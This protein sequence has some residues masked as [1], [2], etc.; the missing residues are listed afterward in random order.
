MISAS[1][2]ELLRGRFA[3]I[4]HGAVGDDGH[5]LAGPHDVALADGHLV[6]PLGHVALGV[7]APRHRGFVRVAV[8]GSVVDALRLEEDDRVIV[9]DGRDQQALGIVGIARHHHFHAADVRED[10]LGTLRV[11]LATANA[12]AAGR[13]DHDRRGEIAGAAITDARELARDLVHRRVD[14]VGELDL[15]DRLQPV[16]GHADGR[17]HDAALGDRRIEHAL[18]AVFS[19]QAIGDAEHATKIANVF[20]HDD[21]GRI[22]RHHH[23][24]GGVQGLDHVHL[25]HGQSTL[26]T[27]PSS[28]L[29]LISS[30]S[31]SLCRR[32]FSGNSL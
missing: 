7:R 25:R 19:L 22:S 9:F 11:R 15:G 14:V 30:A 28:A 17:G 18:I 23:I 3:D 21:D 6:V 2:F 1:M 24:H 12:A 8:E 27:S 10:G 13:A 20:S 4:H 29:S 31:C 5:L 26:A 32:R 16:H